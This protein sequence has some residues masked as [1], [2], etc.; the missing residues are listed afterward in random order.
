MLEA[1]GVPAD[2]RGELPCLRV[3]VVAERREV[4]GVPGASGWEEG[5]LIAEDEG[6][7]G[8]ESVDDDEGFEGDGGV[9]G[10]VEALHECGH[11]GAG[12]NPGAMAEGE[13]GGKA[14]VRWGGTGG[15]DGGG[16][17]D[18]DVCV[19]GGAVERDGGSD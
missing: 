16:A 8:D 1:L 19:G 7:A 14:A 4:E 13:D 11:A 9:G 10:G 6:G 15:G 18:G 2:P 5:E 12:V 3:G 17:E